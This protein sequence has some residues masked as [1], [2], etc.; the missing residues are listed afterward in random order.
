MIVY[1]DVLKRLKKAGW[2]TNRLVKEKVLGNSTI[3]RLRNKEP[4]N[5][6]TIDVICKLCECQ[7]GDLITYEPDPEEGEVE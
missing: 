6:T 2:P 3:T 4:I 5:T 7:P 1:H